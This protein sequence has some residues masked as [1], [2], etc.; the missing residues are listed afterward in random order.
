MNTTPPQ[1]TSIFVAP[2][3]SSVAR[4]HSPRWARSGRHADVLF[5]LALGVVLLAAYFATTTPTQAQALLV[6]YNFTGGTA[7]GSSVAANMT[8]GNAFWT[9]MATSSNFGFSAVANDAFARFDAVGTTT[10]N[11][12]R[13]LEFTLSA[14]PGYFLNLSSIDF[15]IGISST[16]TATRTSRGIARSSVDSFAG[17]LGLTPGLTNTASITATNT[18]TSIYNPYS[19]ALGGASYSNLSSFTFRLYPFVSSSQ[20]TSFLRFDDVAFNGT[21]EVVPEP[22]T[23]TLLGVGLVVSAATVYG[24]KRREAAGGRS[25]RR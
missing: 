6:N 12:N 7:A 10:L 8:A 25:A 1:P 16:A 20:T 11:T 18:T 24:R 21:V 22:A 2:S 13:Y 5:K 15:N 4:A 17:D 14:A 3:F 9:N 23:W 19:I